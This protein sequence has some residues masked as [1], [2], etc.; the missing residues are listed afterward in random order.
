MENIK[1]S[2]SDFLSQYNAEAKDILWHDQSAVF[3][4]FWNER[5]LSADKAD[6]NDFETDHIVQILDRN[7]KGN[8][9]DSEAIAKAMIPQGAWRRMFNEIKRNST[10]SKLLTGVFT[11]ENPDER[12]KLIE[13]VYKVNESR[14]NNLTGQSGSAVNDML[15]AWDSLHHLSVISLKDRRKIYEY[16]GFTDGPDF[17]KDS[18]GKKCVLS[19]I[20]IINGFKN[21]GI[22]GSA[23]TLSVFLYY[24][25][26]KE[27]WKTEQEEDTAWDGGKQPVLQDNNISD[28]PALFYME[29]QLEDF[30]IENWDTSELG[31]K[32]SLIEENGELVSQ[33]YSTDIGRIDILV[34]D[35]TTKQ[36]VVIELKRNQTSDDTIGQ[37]A[38][39]MGWIGEHKN[40]G[41]PVKG[42][43]ITGKYDEKLYYA[44]K[45]VPDVEIYIYK[46][47][48]HLNEFK[49][50]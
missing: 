18:V 12:M 34:Q 47:D 39:Y 41:Q 14:K 21:L 31:K 13:E 42:I 35:K 17:D 28:D 49:K 20:A 9:K 3:R 46:V 43:I 16:F 26:C 40:N 19:E 2:F 10:L 37:L 32:Y 25:P 45:K 29:S 30:L 48:F 27:L 22:T 38:R 24:P 33:Q 7:G 1:K 6:L 11:S 15:A 36:Y 4:K 44:L 8:T 5:I 23:R 50:K